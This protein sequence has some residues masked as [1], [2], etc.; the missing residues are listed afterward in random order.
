MCIGKTCKYKCDDGKKCTF[1]DKCNG[2]LCKGT[3]DTCLRYELT[4]SLE[5]D[6]EECG[7][8]E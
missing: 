8:D 5:A 2:G 6:C 3:P 7:N 1:F 4:S